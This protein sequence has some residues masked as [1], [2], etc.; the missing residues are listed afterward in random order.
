VN[1]VE[2]TSE[3]DVFDG[4][5]DTWIS[6]RVRTS[7][8]SDGSIR[9]V[10]YTIDTQNR[11]VYVLGI[12]QDQRELDRVLNHARSVPDV[13]RVVNYALLKDDPRRFASPRGSYVQ[14][15]EGVETDGY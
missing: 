11:V 10:N 8:L 4:A 3:T 13:R 2:V 9:D 6:T 7:I 14:P 5:R 1:D 15:D 12:A